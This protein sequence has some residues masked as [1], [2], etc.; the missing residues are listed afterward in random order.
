METAGTSDCTPLKIFLAG[1]WHN[2]PVQTAEVFEKGWVQFPR[3]WYIVKV[4]KLGNVE[5]LSTGCG[6][7]DVPGKGQEW[8]GGPGSHNI[9]VESIHDFG[10]I[11]GNALTVNGVRV[12][13]PPPGATLTEDQPSGIDAARARIKTTPHGPEP[14]VAKPRKINIAQTLAGAC[15]EAATGPKN[16]R[17]VAHHLDLFRALT[18]SYMPIIAAHHKPS[19][20]RQY[21]G[22]A[23][24]QEAIM[25]IAR[26]CPPGKVDSAKVCALVLKP[27][28]IGPLLN[29]LAALPPMKLR[30]PLE[31]SWWEW[32]ARGTA[33]KKLV[34]HMGGERFANPLSPWFQI[35]MPPPTLGVAMHR[36]LVLL[37][38]MVLDYPP[39]REI[40]AQSLGVLEAWL[41]EHPDEVLDAANTVCQKVLDANAK[42]LES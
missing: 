24:I 29:G 33:I 23:A 37:F 41:C 25:S 8:R 5:V 28:I 16:E 26:N 10:R 9:H 13:P 2:P 15:V 17:S 11:G 4:P 32:A 30:D 35:N 40:G 21:K 7:C 22:R 3:G 39:T 38:G 42:L 34:I 6:T 1:D 18:E 12:Y 27:E 36:I 14:P 20:Y 19:A 31:P